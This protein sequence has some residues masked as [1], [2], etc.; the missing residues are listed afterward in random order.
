MPGVVIQSRAVV[1][2]AAVLVSLALAG[3]ASAGGPLLGLTDTVSNVTTG[4]GQTVETV[5]GAVTDAT[6]AQQASSSGSDQAAAPGQEP[7]PAADTNAAPQPAAPAPTA[8]TAVTAVTREVVAE[9]VPALAATTNQLA[10]AASDAAE[11]VTGAALGN[12]RAVTGSAVAA[13]GAAVTQLTGRALATV[14]AVVEPVLPAAGPLLR[15]VDDTIS[16]T[17]AALVGTVDQVLALPRSQGSNGPTLPPLPVGSSDGPGGLPGA[18]P[19]GEAA[20]A[21]APAERKRK[22]AP[23]ALQAA[24][25]APPGA[26]DSTPIIHRGSPPRVGARDGGTAVP[27][28]AP[29]AR[30]ASP[31]TGSSSAGGASGFAFVGFAVVA[32]LFVLAAPGLGRRLKLW[33]A[34]IRPLAFVSPPER[35]G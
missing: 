25:T 5:G 29:P 32:G 11:P 18:V 22:A 26:L 4:L 27:S 34:L 7:A 16:T 3:P 20:D 28:L 9:S 17:T 24:V 12:M 2:T 13:T 14:A 21:S 1:A 6:G 31:W 33:P 15:Q 23:P 19:P 35:P 30:S 8:V 10:S